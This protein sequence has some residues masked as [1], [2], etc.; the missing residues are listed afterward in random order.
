METGFQFV[1]FMNWQHMH[2][3][4]NIMSTYLSCYA[5]GMYNLWIMSVGGVPWWFWHSAKYHSTRHAD[6]I[7]LNLNL[8]VHTA[9]PDADLHQSIW[10][11]CVNIQIQIQSV[12]TQHS[13]Y[14]LILSYLSW[15]GYQT[16]TLWQYQKLGNL[17]CPK[18]VKIGL[19][20]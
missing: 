14:N 3:R 6:I 20:L 13:F 19:V 12:Y 8:N 15:H 4:L 10:T 18:P 16:A 9:A 11:C 17:P 1:H 7:C 5:A 2:Q